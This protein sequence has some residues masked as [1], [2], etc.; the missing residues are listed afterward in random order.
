MSWELIYAHDSQGNKVSGDKNLLIESVRNG[1]SVRIVMEDEGGTL[2]ATDA[3]GL[4]VKNNNVYA[5]NNSHV[6]L[7][8]QGDILKIQK[9]SYWWMIAVDT[10]GNRDMARWNVGEHKSRGH[11]SDRTAIRWFVA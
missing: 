5:Q 7:E 8:F 3:T 9:D 6:S 1:Q 2:Y 11:T 10:N 4:H